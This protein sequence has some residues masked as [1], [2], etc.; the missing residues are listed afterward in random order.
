MSISITR[1]FLEEP[2]LRSAAFRYGFLAFLLAGAVFAAIVV[3]QLSPSAH[4]RYFGVMIP[5]TLLVN[6]LAFQFRWPVSVQVGLR[7]VAMICCGAMLAYTLMVA[8][9][10]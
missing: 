8:F 9:S 6:H 7:I 10:R 3:A 4:G 2:R 1:L 5:P